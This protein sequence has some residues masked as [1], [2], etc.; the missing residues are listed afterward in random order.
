M[1]SIAYRRLFLLIATLWLCGCETQAVRDNREI[2]RRQDDE[3]A[4]LRAENQRRREEVERRRSEQEE[5]EACRRAFVSFEQAQVASN[6]RAAESYYREG[7]AL[8]PR[9]D[10]AHYELGRILAEGGRSREAREEFEAALKVNPD[11]AAA[12]EELE[13]LPMRGEK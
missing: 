8:C 13:S 3:I 9:D 1:K 11:F 2:L 4:Q 7:L 6:A 10:V 12:R 5:Y